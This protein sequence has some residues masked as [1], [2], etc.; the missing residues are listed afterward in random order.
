MSDPPMTASATDSNPIH[1]DVIRLG[2]L[3][4]FGLMSP[5]TAHTKTANDTNAMNSPTHHSPL[6]RDFRFACPGWTLYTPER[7]RAHEIVFVAPS[8]RSECRHPSPR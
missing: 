5:T 8:S 7:R 2:N 4:A 1:T 3:A 6:I